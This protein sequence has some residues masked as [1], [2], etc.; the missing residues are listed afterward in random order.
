MLPCLLRVFEKRIMM[1]SHGETA[2]LSNRTA[3][4]AALRSPKGKVMLCAA[5][6][7]YHVVDCGRYRQIF[8]MA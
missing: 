2:N 1:L 4:H 7:I 8:A 5:V 6:I 3:S